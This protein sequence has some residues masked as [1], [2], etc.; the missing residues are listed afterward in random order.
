M[1][2]NIVST[3]EFCIYHLIIVIASRISKIQAVGWAKRQ[4]E[5][6][7]RYLAAMCEIRMLRGEITRVKGKANRPT[8]RVRCSQVLACLFTRG[9]KIYHKY[10]SQHFQICR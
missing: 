7:R 8:L 10:I 9:D 6:L 3:L 5:L 4:D 2:N 1:F